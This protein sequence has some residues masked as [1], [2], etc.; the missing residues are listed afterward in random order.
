MKK[1][2]KIKNSRLKTMAKTK[3]VKQRKLVE[4]VRSFSMK[5]NL[6]NF[7]MADFFTSQKVEC[8]ENEANKKSEE[9]YQWCKKQTLKAFNEFSLNESSK[10]DMKNLAE[11]QPKEYFKGQKTTEEER[12]AMAQKGIDDNQEARFGFAGIDEVGNTKFN[13]ID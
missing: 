8:Y 11:N 9:V 10:V 7:Q 12:E 4:I 3:E 2:I 1:L 6:K 5:K 13:R